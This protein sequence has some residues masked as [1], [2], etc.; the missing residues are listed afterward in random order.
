MQT[1]AADLCLLIATKDRQLNLNNLLDSISKSSLLPAKVIVVYAGT[2]ISQIVNKYVSQISIEVIYSPVASQVSQKLIG[3]NSLDQN[4]AWVLFLDDDIILPMDS[5]SILV[6]KY[7]RNPNLKDV[8]GFG[9]KVI[10]LEF[11]KLTFKQQLFLRPFGLYSN[12]SGSVL[13]S[14]HV[15]NYQELLKDTETQ[16]LN[17]ASAWK[18]E[19]L[20]DYSTGF[21]KIDYAAYEDVIFS[22]KVSK[23]NRLY[24]AS[25][26]T[27]INQNIENHRPLTFTQFKAGAYMRYLFVKTNKELSVNKLLF[28][29]LVR[30][31][32]FIK[33]G[34]PNISIL[35][36]FIKSSFIWIDLLLDVITKKNPVNL[37]TKRYN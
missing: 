16:W 31:I 13:K 7:I 8:Y 32:D 5:L 23:S 20:K 26:V 30:N 10:N 9:L 35:S 15:Q 11:R 37:L 18:S 24:F 29:Q 17:G 14:G 22:Y 4:A 3:I 36:R 21:S 19:I 27:V 12:K 28:A 33:N 6:N 25:S 2:D 1:T 34:D